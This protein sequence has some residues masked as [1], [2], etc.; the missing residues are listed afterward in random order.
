[1]KN[2]K[3]RTGPDNFESIK[4]N[5]SYSQPMIFPNMQKYVVVM[6]FHEQMCLWW[7]A[8]INDTNM[9]CKIGKKQYNFGILSKLEI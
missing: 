3:E 2:V 6:N 5:F 4:T 7:C 1:M 8:I 9:S